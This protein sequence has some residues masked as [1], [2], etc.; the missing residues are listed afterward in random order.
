M[1]FVPFCKLNKNQRNN[2]QEKRT[3]KHKKNKNQSSLII[4]IFRLPNNLDF[5]AKA[6]MKKIKNYIVRKSCK[7]RTL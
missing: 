6:V 2:N 7:I 4:K 5:A 3:M 1:R